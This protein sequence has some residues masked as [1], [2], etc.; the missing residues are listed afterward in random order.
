MRSTNVADIVNSCKDR[1][2]LLACLCGS[3]NDQDKAFDLT[4]EIHY[5]GLLNCQTWKKQT[6]YETQKALSFSFLNRCI[7][8]KRLKE[9]LYNCQAFSSLF[10][11]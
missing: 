9:G 8:K 2:V 4:S 11:N 10:W 1:L 3:I 6:E 5:Y 7:T